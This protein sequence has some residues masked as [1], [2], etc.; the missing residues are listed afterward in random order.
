MSAANALAKNKA[1]RPERSSGS[2]L[3]RITSLEKSMLDSLPVNVLTCDP[4]TFKITYANR[5]SRDTLDQLA[6]LLPAGVNGD[7]IVGQSIDVFHKN[8][9]HQRRMLA[10][11]EANL[12]HHAIIRL[13]PELLE[14][15]VSAVPHKGKKV[16][17]LMLSWTVVTERER[18]KRMVDN[19]PINVMMCDPETF[20]INYAN[21][22]SVET[23]RSIEHLLPIKADNLLGTCIDVFHKMPEMQ[24]KLLKDPANLPHNAKIK[25]GEETL[26]LDV[27]AIID[28]SGYYI[29]PMVSWSVITQEES[30]ATTVSE[31][32]DTVAT[33]AEQLRGNSQE[34]DGTSETASSQLNT[35]AAATE[36]A[37]A[38]VA[39]VAAA[40][41]EL[42]ATLDDIS[43]QIMTAND[44]TRNAVTQANE[45]NAKVE[46]LASAAER[47]GEV[48]TLIKDIADQTNLLALN[49]TIE[50]ARAGE[51]GKGFAVVA[52]EVKSLANQ[53][54]GATNDITDQISTIQTEIGSTIEGIKTI[55]DIIGQVE[56]I[57]TTIAAAVEEQTAAVR[58]IASNAQHASQGTE[59]V[60]S[61]VA[62]VSSGVSTAREL[63][64]AV[65]SAANNLSEQAEAL[66][67]QITAFL[68]R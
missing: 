36:E 20:E 62:G 41:E 35:V 46:S 33:A 8:P 3:G 44:I 13:G 10:D 64:G 43:R 18:L 29:G 1:D 21:K 60:S 15:N 4:K 32:T 67:K 25:L 45:S 61:N 59:E 34:L 47:I 58:E 56:E 6:H 53:T 57:S 63:A 9:E 22:T 50:A 16:G 40:T 7:N 12:P 68:E 2:V 5:T 49:A 54:A 65:Q 55:S 42:S 38:N 19:M 51:A 24:R 31:I 23:L 39:T 66:K 14:L 28:N 17:A 30:L 11:P 27:S 48:I 37:S 26:K 52:S